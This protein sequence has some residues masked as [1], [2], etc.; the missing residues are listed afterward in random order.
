M[1]KELYAVCGAS[2]HAVYETLLATNSSSDSLTERFL[3]SGMQPGY[4]LAILFDGISNF[5][6]QPKRDR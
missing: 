1:N 3:D 5:S 6:T 4:R 2:L